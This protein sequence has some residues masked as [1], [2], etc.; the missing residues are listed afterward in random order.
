MVAH[1]GPMGQ[2]RRAEGPAHARECVTPACNR[3][4]VLVTEVSPLGYAS[5]SVRAPRPDASYRRGLVIP[6]AARHAVGV[7]AVGIQ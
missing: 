2:D 1:E 6:V 4:V 7:V 5:S 3:P